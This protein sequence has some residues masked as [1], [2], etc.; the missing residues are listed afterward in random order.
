MY[1][2]TEPIGGLFVFYYHHISCRSEKEL[3]LLLRNSQRGT[4]HYD[5]KPN[6]TYIK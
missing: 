3:I 4:L 5:R 2:L 1:K 6:S